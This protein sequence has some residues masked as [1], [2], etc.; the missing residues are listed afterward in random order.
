LNSAHNIAAQDAR[1]F[2]TSIGAV[3]VLYFDYKTSGGTRPDDHERKEWPAGLRIGGFGLEKHDKRRILP[4][5]GE[6]LRELF[7][8][9]FLNYFARIYEYI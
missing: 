3:S 1:I 2:E 8:S 6:F 5:P 7:T 4:S 9:S